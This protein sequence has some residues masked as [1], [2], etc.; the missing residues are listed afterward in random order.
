MEENK[1]SKSE[2]CYE[3][4]TSTQTSEALQTDLDNGLSEEEAKKR[5][6]K[7]GENKL[8]EKRKNLQLESFLNK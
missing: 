6:E 3:T 8:E 1:D 2:V 7:Y 4:L 5:L